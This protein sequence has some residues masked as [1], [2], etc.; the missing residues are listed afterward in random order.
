MNDNKDVGFGP[1]NVFYRGNKSLPT[2]DVQ[3]EWTPEMIKEIDKCSKNLLHFGTHYFWAVTVEDGKRQ[4]QLYK[5]QKELLKLLAKERFV[6]TVASRQV[7]KSTAMSIFALWMTCF[8]DDKRV[9]IVANR[10]D[11]AIELLRRIKFAYEMLPNWLKPGVE[12]WGQT[13]VYFANGS[14]IEISA[15]SSTAARGKSINCVDGKTMVTIRNKKTGEVLNINM[16]T[17]A[18]LLKTNETI[19][20]TMMVN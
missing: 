7:G 18:S 14:S 3:F 2:S 5:P 16:E 15:T 20:N 8:S 11:T 4:L 9:L 19:K 10:E 17:L 1:Q 13:S 12:T 6:I